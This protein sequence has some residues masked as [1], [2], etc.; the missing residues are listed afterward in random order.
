MTRKMDADERP[1]F[2][3]TAAVSGAG[4]FP[5]DMLRYDSCWPS[6]SDDVIAMSATIR[7]GELYKKYRTVHIVSYWP[8]TPE[9]WRSFG[10]QCIADP[11][12]G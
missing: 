1:R 3:Y 6:A 11:P 10:W 7:D 2:L 12:T 5:H 4:S 8:F 9:R